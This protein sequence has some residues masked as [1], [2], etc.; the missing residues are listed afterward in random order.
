MGDIE[1]K[2]FWIYKADDIIAVSHNTKKDILKFYPDINPEK[3][4]VIPVSTNKDILQKQPMFELPKKYFLY[5]GGRSY[6]Y[7]NFGR[8]FNVAMKILKNN[9]EIHLLIVGG[10]KLEGKEKEILERTGVEKRVHVVSA[11]D[12]ELAYI[13]ERAECFIHPSLYEGFGVTILE[14]FTNRCP[15]VC[16]DASSFPE[17][18]EDAAIYFDPMSEESMYEK[19]MQVLS[20]DTL[21][22]KLRENGIEQLKKFSWDTMVQE[23]MEVYKK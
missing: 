12:N 3:I 13:Y 20:S 17:V 2:R 6:D 10:E 1:G 5:V 21:K 18:A 16:S 23:T 9:E 15:V 7:K 14:A 11:S 22:N 19:I 4:T 8:F